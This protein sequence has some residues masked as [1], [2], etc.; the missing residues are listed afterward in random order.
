MEEV[1]Q[2][3]LC[4]RGPFPGQPE[5]HPVHLAAF[6]VVDLLESERLEPPRGPWAHVSLEVVAVGDNHSRA[7]ADSA[8]NCFRGRLMAPVMCAPSYSAL[9]STSTTWAPSE[10]SR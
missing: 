6:V 4:P 10:R 1:A 5:G 8:F 9:G 7:V 3:R 2:P